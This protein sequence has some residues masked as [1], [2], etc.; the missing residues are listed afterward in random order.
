VTHHL[1]D[2]LAAG[3]PNAEWE[4]EKAGW[5]AQV[6]GNSACCYRRGSRLAGAWHRGF[7]AA[8]HSS[9]PLGLML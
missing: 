9:D 2:L 8:A 6:M 1:L 5:R 7:D 4:A 3:P